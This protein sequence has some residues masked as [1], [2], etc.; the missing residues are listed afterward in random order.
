[1]GAMNIS[2]VVLDA[3]YR[4]ASRDWP[5][6]APTEVGFKLPRMMLFAV[7]SRET[8]LTNEYGDYGW[9]NGSPG[10]LPG[11]AWAAGVWQLDAGSHVIPTY[12]MDNVLDQAHTA[13]G[14]LAA[15]LAEFGS[16]RMAVAAYNAGAGT[17]RYNLDNHLDIDTG[18]AGGDYSA[19][20]TARMTY[21]QDAHP[22]P[23]HPPLPAMEDEPMDLIL[24]GANEAEGIWLSGGVAMTSNSNQERL[25]WEAKTGRKP[26]V[27]SAGEFGRA[28]ATWVK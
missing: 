19:D 21:L 9:R 23:V 1:M 18:T 4:I 2:P 5:F 11:G 25:D 6:I 8:N 16:Q 17:V 22:L 24:N 7:G 3:Q 27:W 14:M 20:V 28:M 15:L 13:A 26:L 12:F 10:P